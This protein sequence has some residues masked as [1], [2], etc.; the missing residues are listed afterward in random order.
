MIRVNGVEL[1]ASLKQIDRVRREVGM[2]FQQFN[3]F[4]HLTVLRELRARA[5]VGRGREAP[6][7]GERAHATRKSAASPTRRTNIRP[8]FPAGSSSASPSPA[9]SA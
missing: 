2:V 9:R 7:G 1:T 8:N 5:D 6:G 4:P 3:L